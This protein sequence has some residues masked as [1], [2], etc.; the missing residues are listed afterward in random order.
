MLVIEN[1]FRDLFL[2]LSIFE[3]RDIQLGWE[4]QENVTALILNASSKLIVYRF[5]VEIIKGIYVK[6]HNIFNYML[7][8]D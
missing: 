2:N 7:Q 5:E 6:L 8:V 3:T 1:L 4:I